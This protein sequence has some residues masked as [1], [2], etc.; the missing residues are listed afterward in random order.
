MQLRNAVLLAAT[1]GGCG[2]NPP[3]EQVETLTP[4]PPGAPSA[5][6]D[7]RLTCLGNNPSPPSSSNQVVLPGWIRYYTD[8]TAGKKVTPAARVEA[9]STSGASLGVSFASKTDGR[10]EVTVPIASN[11]WTGHVEATC[12]AAC[13]GTAQGLVEYDFWTNR[14]YTQPEVAGWAWMISHDD[15]T[16]LAAKNMVT[17]DDSKAIAAIGVHDCDHFGIGNAVVEV[18]GSVSGGI[19]LEGFDVAPG[20]AYSAASGRVVFPNL[21]PGDAVVKAFARTVAGGPLTLLASITVKLKA[22]AITG[23]DLEPRNGTK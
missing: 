18:N 21:P 15:L 13:T 10:V 16:A 4:E 19:Y 17:V 8:P 1:L 23:I 12:D 2:P 11:G 22:G 9:F 3:V 6:A 14:V 20:K 5:L 7:G